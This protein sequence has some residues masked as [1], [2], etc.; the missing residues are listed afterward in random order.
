MYYPFIVNV[1]VSEV[2]QFLSLELTSL[3]LDH[4]YLLFPSLL[5]QQRILKPFL[6][7]TSNQSPVIK[8]NV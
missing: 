2:D 4:H 1:V 7:L 6:Y 8:H 3:F 5:D